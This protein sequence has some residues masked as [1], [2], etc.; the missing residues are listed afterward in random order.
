MVAGKTANERTDKTPYF[1]GV[2]GGAFA[3][4]TILF[5]FI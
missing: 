2:R 5:L 3:R 1:P 4:F